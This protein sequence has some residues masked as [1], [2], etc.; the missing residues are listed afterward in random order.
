MTAITDASVGV[1][2]P[3]TMPPTMI[4]GVTKARLARSKAQKNSLSE[5]R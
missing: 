3:G 1:K 2:N 4:A 5:A